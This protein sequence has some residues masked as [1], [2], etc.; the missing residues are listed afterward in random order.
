MM[1]KYRL[2][3]P[4]QAMRHPPAGTEIAEYRVKLPAGAMLYESCRTLRNFHGNDW[5]L[6]GRA[7][8]FSLP[9]RLAPES[10]ASSH[11]LNRRQLGSGGLILPRRDGV[12]VLTAEHDHE[13]AM[14]RI[15]S[16]VPN[17]GFELFRPVP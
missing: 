2:T 6:L 3:A 12:L 8:L 11:R 7:A 15:V 14:K 4:I 13:G 10:R 9:T 5:C 1:T 16:L 17:R